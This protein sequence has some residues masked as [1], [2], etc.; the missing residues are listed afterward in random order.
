M[1]SVLLFTEN[2]W[3]FGSLHHALIKRLWDHRIYANLINWGICY[4]TKEHQYFQHRYRQVCTP[5]DGISALLASG[6]PAS[7][8]IGVAHSERDIV[9][10][11]S[12]HEESIVDQLKGYAV[13]NK[14]MVKVS[15][16]LGIRRVPTVVRVGVDTEFFTMPLPARLHT[17]GYAGAKTFEMSNK[18]E[19][20]RGHLIP[21][22]IE[23]LNVS[24]NEHA[25]Y[26]HFAMPGYY[27]DIDAVLVTSNY[28]TVGLPALEAAAAGRLP[29]G[30]R[31]GYFDGS[32]GHLCRTP[33]DEFVADAREAISRY[34][35]DREAFRIACINVRQAVRDQYDWGKCVVDWVSLFD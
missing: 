29:L 15:A 5:I 2:Q 30:A 26:N 14:S 18:S 24:L 7:K 9:L 10:T 3:A 35:K 27:S 32:Y 20:K 13:V 21:R 8:I 23:G 22:V 6:W 31:V 1:N 12:R 33:D 25:F 16:D 19:C 34:T 4:T 17:M 11:L 28:E